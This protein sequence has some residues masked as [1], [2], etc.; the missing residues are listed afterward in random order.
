MAAGKKFPFK[1]MTPCNIGNPQAVGQGHMTF[2]R[3]VLS[4]ALNPDLLKT[5]ALSKDAEERVRLFLS[6]AGSPMGAYTSNSKGYEFVRE[7]V[8]KFIEKR[9]GPAV[10]CDVN[11]IYLTNGASEG[12]R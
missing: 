1:K 6:Q 10:K 11:N 3:E 7:A 5:G 2:N 8:C 12:V 4:G 9:D